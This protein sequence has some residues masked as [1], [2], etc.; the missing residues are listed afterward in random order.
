MLKI[1]RFFY[2]FSGLIIIF[3]A[4]FFGCNQIA[5]F[6][7]KIFT[8]SV[9]T[10][11]VSDIPNASQPDKN[12]SEE[13]YFDGP[14][15][16][17][18]QAISV[19]DQ[20]DDIQEKID[21][22]K[23]QVNELI[24]ESE[25]NN[26]PDKEDKVAD[27][28]KDQDSK[29]DKNKEDDSQ[30]KNEK[31]GETNVCAGQIN[32]NTASA[33]DLDKITQI[34]P[35]TAL[36]IISARPFYSLNDLLRVNGIGEETLQKITIQGCAYVENMPIVSGGGGAGNTPIAYPKILISEVQIYPIGQR[37]VELYNPNNTDVDL[38]NWYL[39]RKDSND[40]SWNSF[41]SSAKFSGKIIPGN[42]YFLISRADSTADILFSDMTLAPNNSLALKSP[43][44]KIVD[45][46][47]WSQI[48][49]NLSWCADF[50]L[51]SPTP[52]AKNIAYVVPPVP[53][54][55]GIVITTPATKVAYF[56][57]DLLDISGLVV[58]GTYSDLSTQVEP[59]TLDNITGFDSISPTTG[60]VLTIN[61]EA[62]TTTYTVN[63]TEPQVVLKNILINRIQ[64]NPI[65][66]R[67]VELYNPNNQSVDLTGWYVQRKTQ[68]AGSWGSFISST[69]FAGKSISAN[70]YFM[71]SRQLENSDILS[72]ITLSDNNS[73]ALK[74]PSRDIVDKVGWGLAGDFET[75]P[76]QNP[77]AFEI[78][79]RTLGVDTNN[80]S[81]DFSLI[82]TTSPSDL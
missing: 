32:I 61:F 81:L 57:G 76:A 13:G 59:V 14:V 74:N 20:L 19:G 39:Q 62:Q 12:P 8:A 15:T 47:A 35:V 25:K 54:L 77:A 66:Q 7:D 53:T 29:N 73:L 70:G 26:Q 28:K 40:I 67:F 11:V 48:A 33:E 5:G 18:P 65:E 3:A 34:G 24:A 22:I 30:V 75:A 21:I 64:V 71:I 17:S 72:N 82:D 60:Q 44:E 41:V 69:N 78:L 68:N 52:R 51:C 45:Q 38:T 63:I 80:N 27:D 10:P 36:K 50:S 4:G 58:T 55:S 49:D 79:S 56:T 16:I 43:D 2:F 31:S 23:Q 37:F 42:G 46:V 1:S 9:S 6:S